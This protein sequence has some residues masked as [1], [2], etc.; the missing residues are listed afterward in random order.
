MFGLL[1]TLLG[2][3]KALTAMSDPAKLGPAMALALSSAFIGI[4]VANFLCI[5]IAGQIRLLAMRETLLL[6]MILEGALDIAVNRPAYQ[7]EMRMASYLE[8]PVAPPA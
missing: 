5:P 3:L 6:E 4:G 2:M 1:G 7:V 8:S